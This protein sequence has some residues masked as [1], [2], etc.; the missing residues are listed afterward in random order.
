VLL[1]RRSL[2]PRSMKNQGLAGDWSTMSTAGE[3]VGSDRGEGG[4]VSIPP[5]L[6]HDIPY[7]YLSPTIKKFL[8]RRIVIARLRHSD[9]SL[10]KRTCREHCENS[11]VV[12][13]QRQY[14]VRKRFRVKTY[15][16]PR[17]ATSIY[18]LLQRLQ[19]HCKI[20]V[21]NMRLTMI[22]VAFLGK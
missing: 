15:G 16:H 4:G 12:R 19:Q 7:C 10:K 2:T 3:E 11:L 20:M 5:P 1:S 6:L 17:P 13:L 21:P 14:F 22:K 8:P 9:N 18:L